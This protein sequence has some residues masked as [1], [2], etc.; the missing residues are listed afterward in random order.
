MCA[1]RT[2]FAVSLLHQNCY[3]LNVKLVEMWK[4][5]HHASISLLCIIYMC[6]PVGIVILLRHI[7]LML[8]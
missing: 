3:I 4:T 2:D 5:M 8:Y 6:A 7:L 1:W